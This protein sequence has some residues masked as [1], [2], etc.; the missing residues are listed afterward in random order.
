MNI[1]RE[2]N[3]AMLR[4]AVVRLREMV[5]QLRDE[6]AAL[7]NEV[8]RLRAK[9]RRMKDPNRTTLD[10]GPSYTLEHLLEGEIE[11]LDEA[12]LEQMLGIEERFARA[13]KRPSLKED[14]S[15][16]SGEFDADAD[17]AI[18]QSSANR[19][20]PASRHF[21]RGASPEASRARGLEPN[22]SMPRPNVDLGYINQVD[23][24]ELDALPYGL[25]VLDADG[26][27]LFYNETESRYAGYEREDV[28]GKN[29]FLDVAPCTRV[30]EF[31]GRF[32][33]FVAGKLGPVAFF[34]FAF[35]F[36]E[37]TQNVVIGLSH[38]R[39]KGHY[40]VMMTRQ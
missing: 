39:R 30:K 2:D 36:E 33:D 10:G 22:A 15:A 1:A 8:V 25:I 31:Q 21:G 35:H 27:V 32:L 12:T 17:M 29:F 40:N 26:R 9:V 34:D 13:R 3:T 4:K 6:K 28:L 14:T 7:E 24:D 23:P 16:W 37:G 11:D 38:G 18:Y 20:V 5:V 19:H